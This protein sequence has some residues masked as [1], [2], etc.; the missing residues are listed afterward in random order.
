MN[1]SPDII[2]DEEIIKILNNLKEKF[3]GQEIKYG[4]T[5]EDFKIVN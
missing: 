3:K 2:S 1:E 5:E 4:I